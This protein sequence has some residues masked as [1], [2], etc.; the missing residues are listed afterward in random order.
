[1]KDPNEIRALKAAFRGAIDTA[2]A[3]TALQPSVDGVDEHGDIAPEL[4]EAIRPVI[5]AHAVASAA[6]R[7]LVDTIDARR[8]AS[9]T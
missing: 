4:L 6:L 7:G 2:A 1:M 3:L 8:S 5:A 9:A